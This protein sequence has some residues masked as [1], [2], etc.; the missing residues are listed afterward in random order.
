MA[1]T[2]PSQ[3]QRDAEAAEMSPSALAESD[4]AQLANFRATL[5][6]LVRQTELEAQK[7]GLTPQH[8]HLMLAIKGFPGRDWANI[9]ELAERLQIRHNAVIG[10]IKRAMA[11]GLVARRQSDQG[12]DRRT[13][14]ISL[15]PEGER[16]LRILVSALRDER[17]RVS[18]A[19]E[20]MARG[21]ATPAPHA[22]A[23]S[24]E[25]STPLS[26]HRA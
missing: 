22:T 10:L 16:V 4:Y 25:T 5:R 13:V 21:S 3:D 26:N 24:A 8:Y 18:D 7:V 15:T 23:P 6:Q 14:R 17:K 19:V 20:A 11:R 9:S 1:K 2:I 12:A